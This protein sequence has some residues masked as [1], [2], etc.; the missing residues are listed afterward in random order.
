MAGKPLYWE[1]RVD[2]CLHVVIMAM[3]RQ[4]SNPFKFKSSK[5]LQASA[6]LL[7]EHMHEQM[8]FLRLLKLLY[9]SERACLDRIGSMI[10]GDTV[11][12][13]KDGPVLSRTYDMIKKLSQNGL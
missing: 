12:S 1:L 3:E 7:H 4:L 10:T 8:T 9:L 2:V 13:M 11:V 5:V 6:I